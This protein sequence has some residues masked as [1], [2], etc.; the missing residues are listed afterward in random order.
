MKMTD[1]NHQWKLNK[2]TH[3]PFRETAEALQEVGVSKRKK[4]DEL[5]VL[6]CSKLSKLCTK[7]CAQLLK[8]CPNG[9]GLQKNVSRGKTGLLNSTLHRRKSF[10]L[11]NVATA[12]HEFSEEGSVFAVDPADESTAG[13]DSC[14]GFFQIYLQQKHTKVASGRNHDDGIADRV[15]RRWTSSS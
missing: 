8:E 12:L 14:V 11:A 5:P 7:T 13:V 3:P 2:A 15:I 10:D 4:N 9:D 6:A 1:T